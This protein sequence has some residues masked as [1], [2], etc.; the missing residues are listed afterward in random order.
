M[1][2]QEEMFTEQE[3]EVKSPRLQWLADN[4]ISLTKM[5]NG[6]WICRGKAGGVYWKEGDSEDDAITAWS[7]YSN[8]KR[9][10]E[11]TWDE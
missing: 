6:K 10:D 7:T 9:W 1:C 8:V 2:R 3:V 4:E 5:D 11:R